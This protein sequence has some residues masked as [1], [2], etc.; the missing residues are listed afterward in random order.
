MVT[1]GLGAN[2]SA[3]T[4]NCIIKWYYPK[5]WMKKGILFHLLIHVFASGCA[6]SQD[7]T[8]TPGMRMPQ[9][10]ALH[11]WH[12]PR[13]SRTDGIFYLSG[14]T[15]GT[16]GEGR[17]LQELLP[18]WFCKSIGTTLGFQTSPTIPSAELESYCW[19]T[20][21]VEKME[22][23]QSLGKISRTWKGA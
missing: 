21:S 12:M 23:P 8:C 18:H 17:V 1:S 6:C 15:Q 11:M 22:E 2:T 10:R 19:Y 13:L 9:Q 4:T 7:A 3:W 20:Q 5:F 14:T 16:G